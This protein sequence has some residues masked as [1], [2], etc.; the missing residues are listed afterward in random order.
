MRTQNEMRMWKSFE[1]F[2]DPSGNPTCCKNYQTGKFC[3]FL[4]SQSFGTDHTCFF[5]DY[6]GKGQGV[7]LENYGGNPEGY[8]KPCEQCPFWGTEKS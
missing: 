6:K 8:L 2:R 1:V 5:A 7:S 4:M 3:R